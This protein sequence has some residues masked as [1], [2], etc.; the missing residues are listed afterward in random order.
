MDGS[1]H[2]RGGGPVDD[3]HGAPAGAEGATGRTPHVARLKKRVEFQRASRGGRA[4]GV[5]VTLQVLKRDDAGSNGGVARFGFTVTKKVGGAV[6]RNRIRRRLRDA[7][8]APG[9]AVEAGHDYVLVARREALTMRFAD[10]VADLAGMLR[11]G[12]LPQGRRDG[13][14]RSR[15]GTAARVDGR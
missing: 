1:R 13:R 3:V 9:L 4:R 6:E 7:L 12:C 14:G 11:L 10:L 5:A 2:D 15:A 8:R